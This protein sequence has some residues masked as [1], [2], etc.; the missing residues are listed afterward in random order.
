MTLIYL[1]T[2]W[3]IG[4]AAAHYF[5]PPLTVVGL[6]TVLP[7]AALLLWRD[8]SKVRRIAAC[9]LFLLLGSARYT[10][11]LPDLDSPGHIAAYRDQGEV[12]LWGRAIGAPDVRDTYT[13]L[14]LAVDR[15]RIDDEEHLVRGR[16]LVRAS[17]YPIYRYGDELEVEGKLETPPVF[18]EFSYRDYLAWQGIHGMV[19]WPKIRL[20]SRGGGSPI[21]RT[22]L[23]FKARA[24]ATIARILPEP[25][26]S[27]LTGILLGVEAGIPEGVKDAFSA[28]GTTHV[29]AISG[30]N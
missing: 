4:I 8:D 10:L 15:V 5:S 17:R 12:T 22:L 27:L 19:G 6:L 25:E 7:L 14:R 18:K 2:A 16:I 13:N 11:S 3:L 21:Y 24:Q 29:I 23:S 30:F 26:A 28:T 1:S 20:L 9:G